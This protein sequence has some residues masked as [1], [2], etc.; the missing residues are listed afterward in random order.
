MKKFKFNKI[1]I[2]IVLAI[3]FTLG[4]VGTVSVFAANNPVLGLSST[5]GI[6]SSTFTR[7][8]GVT[9]ITGDLGYTTLSGGG[10]HTVSGTTYVADTTYDTAG[11]NQGTA[12][13]NLNLEACD[14]TFAAGA[15][16]LATDTTHV[17][18]TPS[19]GS[20]AGEYIPGVYCTAAASAASVGTGGITLKGVG[21][22]IFK[23]NGALTTVDNSEVRLSDSASSCD[24]FWAPTSATTLGADTTFVGT[25]IDAAGIT[26]GH[27]TGWNGRA[28]AFGGTVTTDTNTID[29]TCLTTNPTVLVDEVIPPT[30]NVIK[31][32]SGGTASAG[33]WLLTVSSSND[34][35]GIGS[36]VGS[37]TAT[38]YTLETGKQYSVEESGG[39]SG[40]TPSSS[41]DCTIG[42]ATEDT[43]YNCTI[44]NT[45]R[46]QSSSGSIPRVVV[47]IFEPTITI[48]STPVVIAPIIPKLPKTGFAPQESVTWYES[49]LNNI[50]NL[51]R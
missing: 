21:T 28:L 44:T 12:L 38:A 29:S 35:T 47:P 11:T 13:S 41:D 3:M 16:N 39:P 26:V 25:V 45:Y 49:L 18:N 37:E 2:I 20:V 31:N 33:D 50:L 15:I 36:A 43:I 10:T 22:Y 6:L 32:V 7:N 24:V 48:L 34:G 9:V 5:F 14:F 27:N 1:S 51:F 40:Y 23:I 17:T 46:R 30:L 19:W 42:S 4:L 8:I